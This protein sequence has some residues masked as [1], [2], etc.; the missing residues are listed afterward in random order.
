M[1]IVHRKR[2]FKNIDDLNLFVTKYQDIMIKSI[3][4]KFKIDTHDSTYNLWNFSR[5]M[6]LH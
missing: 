6:P 5:K 1:V 3:E 2:I 4:I